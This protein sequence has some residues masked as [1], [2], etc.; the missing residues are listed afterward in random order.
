M[1][2]TLTSILLAATIGITGCSMREYEE[3]TVIKEYGNIPGLI[4]SEG[5][6]FG[7]NSV[8]IN[9]P[10]YVLQIKTEKG[11][12]TANVINHG[13][14]HLEALSVAIE[15]GTK[16]RFA[17]KNK[18]YDNL[19]FDKDRIGNVFSSDIEILEK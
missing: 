5:A 9:D 13:K 8:K 1:K 10:T 6:L 7:N 18:N 19:G 4:K 15:E 16:I 3:G 2:K 14:K 11:I 17:V 12:Y